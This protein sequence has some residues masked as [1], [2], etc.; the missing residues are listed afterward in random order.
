MAEIHELTTDRLRL[1]AWRSEDRG[2]FADLNAD[3]EVM[4][5]FPSVLSRS[6][7]DDLVDRIEDRMA[8]SGWG[9]WAVEVADG[10]EFIGFVGINPVPF[11]EVFTPAV[12]VGWRLARAHW[13]N[14]Y[15][16]EAARAALAFGF[17]VVG[18]DHIVSFTA[19]PNERSQSVMR[20]IGMHR[21]LEFDHPRMPE[22]HWLRRHVLYS[23][24]LPEAF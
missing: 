14:G 6:E 7:S 20:K 11:D 13:G 10:P 4:E 17:D 16:P 19:L 24:E 22:G 21:T 5:Y 15:A 23:I 12:E 3:P 9:L 18:L 2:P 8:E 1:R